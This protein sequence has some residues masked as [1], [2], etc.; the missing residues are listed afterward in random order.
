L[1]SALATEEHLFCLDTGASEAGLVRFYDIVSFIDNAYLPDT[2]A[3][4]EAYGD[5]F[6]IGSGCKNLLAYGVFPLTDENGPT[7]QNQF[8]KR[9]RALRAMRN[10]SARSCGRDLAQILEQKIMPGSS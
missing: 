1:A 3:V 2:M 5:Y 9:G 6:Q 8:F 10:C 7:G 4:A